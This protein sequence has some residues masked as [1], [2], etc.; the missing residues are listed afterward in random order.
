M[1]T[2]IG[3]WTNQPT[4]LTTMERYNSN[5]KKPQSEIFFDPS[6]HP[7]DTLKAFDEFIELFQLRYDAQFPD[8]LQSIAW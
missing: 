4:P 1:A 6:E 2:S 3:E 5:N 7:D 8:P